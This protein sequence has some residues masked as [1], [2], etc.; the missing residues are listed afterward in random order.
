MQRLGVMGIII[1]KD[2]SKAE[3][4]QNLLSQFGDMILGRMGLPYP[5]NEVFIISLIVKGTNEQISALS[6][7]I[8]KI[9]GVK[10]KTALTDALIVD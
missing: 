3:L 8:G 6:G 2:R 10:I 5:Q 1:E 9:Q 4:V 7:K